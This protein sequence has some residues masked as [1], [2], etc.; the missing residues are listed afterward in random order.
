MSAS[1]APKK[2]F[3]RQFDEVNKISNM[4]NLLKEIDINNLEPAQYRGILRNS[5]KNDGNSKKYN[6]NVNV[7]NAQITYLNHG[8]VNPHTGQ[9]MNVF[10]KSSKNEY[11]L[12]RSGAKHLEDSPEFAELRKR[13]PDATCR[14][15]STGDVS[16][17][18][19][20]FVEGKA[21]QISTS[22]DIPYEE[23]RTI[24]ADAKIS[25]LYKSVE[26]VCRVF[27]NECK[28]AIENGD[29]F[30]RFLVAEKKK[31]AAITA[32]EALNLYNEANPDIIN[33]HLIIISDTDK[34]ELK[35]YQKDGGLEILLHEILVVPSKEIHVCVKPNNL[36][37]KNGEEVPKRMR[38]F[39]LKLPHNKDGVMTIPIFD[40]N[41]SDSIGKLTQLDHAPSIDGIN[42]EPLNASNIARVL[43]PGTKIDGKFYMVFSITKSGLSAALKA[44]SIGLRFPLSAKVSSSEEFD[45]WEAP[46]VDTIPEED[47]LPP[48]PPKLTRQK[49]V[50]V[51]QSQINDDE[52]EDSDVNLHLRELQEALEG[53]GQ[54]TIQMTEAFENNSVDA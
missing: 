25:L 53:V 48:F 30:V 35:G 28:I 21:E 33:N 49:S 52:D 37:K 27:E 31:N 38:S 34:K 5:F 3:K 45:C 16:I 9:I 40:L 20:E 10:F 7:F 8:I 47:D 42:E 17:D 23:T 18:L 19:S 50:G 41:K 1:S 22:I 36:T 2:E 43:V 6:K 39:K 32:Q 12:C 15:P 4:Y 26:I 14:Y 24:S 54:P 51:K 44:D 29:E 13:D 11:E 46:I